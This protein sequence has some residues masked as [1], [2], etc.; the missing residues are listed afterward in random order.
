[1]D[2][3]PVIAP[4]DVLKQFSGAADRYNSAARLQ[5]GMAWRLAGHCR[6]L[7]IPR[8]LWVDLGS[9]T[10]R[11]ADALEATHPGQSESAGKIKFGASPRAALSLAA[12]AKA[13]A[14]MNERTHASFED[15]KFIAPSVLRHRIIL[16]YNARVEG[17]TSNEIISLLLEEIPF[18]AGKNPRT[19][20]QSASS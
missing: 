9:G 15:V 3:K 10:G 6:H 8:G 4:D 14:L 7:L 18:Q 16:D 20:Q 11:L 5:E 1:M 19:L 12:A 13:R 2:R 17:L